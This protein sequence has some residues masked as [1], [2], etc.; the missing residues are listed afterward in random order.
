MRAIVPFLALLAAFPPLSTDMIL[1]ALPTLAAEWNQ[2]MAVINLV[3]VVFFAAFALGL[4]CYGPISD[5]VGRRPPLFAGLAIYI[6]ASLGCAS[7]QGAYWLVAMRGLQAFGAAAGA[8]MSMAMAKDLFTGSDR[9]RALALIAVIIAIAPMLAPVLGGWTLAFLTW[10]WTF[11]F[12][13]AVGLIALG[14]VFRLSEPLTER[15]EESAW[16]VLHAYGRLLRNPAYLAMAGVM[17]ASLLPIYTFIAGS[18]EIYITGFG[19]SEQVFGYFFGLN[20]LAFMA[21]SFSCMRLTKAVDS[22]KLMTLGFAGIL[23]GGGLILANLVSGPWGFALPMA[24]ITFCLGMS[25]PASNHLVLEQVDR[26]AGS[27]SSLLVFSYFML[28][29]VVMWLISLDWGDK[30][31][32]LGAFGAVCGAA[33]LLGW[34]A[35]RRSG[36]VRLHG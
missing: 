17:T 12:Q 11:L 22:T 27:A 13:A 20:A 29:A 28:G 1:P 16:R 4:L 35:L 34:L 36:L 14:G 5:R 8:S 32:V 23:L 24:L 33:A 15:S 26:D 7:A 31:P 18:S 9:Q 3:L 25:R 19:L 30:V 21:G 10:R 6:L 2:P